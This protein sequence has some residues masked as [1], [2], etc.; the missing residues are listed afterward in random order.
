MAPQTIGGSSSLHKILGFLGFSS[1][2]A[3]PIW[4]YA[5]VLSAT[6]NTAL[7]PIP[8]IGLIVANLALIRLVSRDDPLLK[9]LMLTG[10]G[11]RFLAVGGYIVVLLAIYG[12]GDALLYHE[13][14]ALMATQARE[15]GHYPALFEYPG[16]VFIMRL[17]S[18]VFLLV[19][20]SL[21][22]GMLLYGSIAFWG[23]FLF[24]DAFHSAFP[25][26]DPTL[27]ALLLF[28][29]PSMV[30]WTS[31]IGKDAPMFL[32]SGV[33]C[34]AYARLLDRFHPLSFGLL[35]G[36]LWL[37][38]RIRPHVALMLAASALAALLL[39]RGLPRLSQRASRTIGFALLA[40]ATLLLLPRVEEFLRLESLSLAS[41]REFLE[42]Q[43]TMTTRGGSSF[44]STGSF[45]GRVLASPLLL[46]RPFPWEIHNLPS[47]FAAMENVLIVAMAWVNRHSLLINLRTARSHPL[48]VF[49]LSFSALFVLAFSGIGNFGILVRQRVMLLPWI[50]ILLTRVEDREEVVPLENDPEPEGRTPSQPLE[51]TATGT[52]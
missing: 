28:F 20:D 18:Y 47:V 43:L 26:R 31:S 30:F 27:I 45:F 17:T 13:Q 2:L 49:A 21:V 9:R 3:L 10:Y 15:Y 25:R 32:L 1:A 37:I 38:S 35:L 16:A 52:G 46:V 6:R 33:V 12:V 5:L 4:A 42:W 19:G 22:P 48:F 11:Y 29:L 24:L 39:S 44:G 50:L 40:A 23:A 14:G 7:F 51:T 41:S 8:T 34:A 36:A